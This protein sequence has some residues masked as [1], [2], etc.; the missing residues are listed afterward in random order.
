MAMADPSINPK[1]DADSESRM[2]ENPNSGPITIPNPNPASSNMLSTGNGQQV[3]SVF[4]LVRF[5]YDSGGGALMGS[6]FGYGSGL[7][8]K[9]GFKGSFVDA[10]ASAKT[11]ALLSGVNGLVLCLLKKLRGK[12]DGVAGCC[13]G[14]A[15]GYPGTPQSLLQSCLTFGAFSFVIEGLNKRQQPALA[16]SYPPQEILSGRHKNLIPSLAFPLPSDLMAPFNAFCLSLT[17]PGNVKSKN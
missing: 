1:T 13:T 6:I 5:A 14:L 2:D 10:A 9:K 3:S 16:L 15:I 11:F 8:N 7:F 17:K 4:C 12:D